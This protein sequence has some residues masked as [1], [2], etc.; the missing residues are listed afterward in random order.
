MSPVNNY[1][2]SGS[3]LPPDSFDPS[4]D[5]AVS[6]SS[7]GSSRRPL[8]AISPATA[9]RLESMGKQVATMLT[10]TP[11]NK[12]STRDNAAGDSLPCQAQAIVRSLGGVP[13]A[14]E[15]WLDQQ[16]KSCRIPSESVVAKW[17]HAKPKT[18]GRS[19]IKRGTNAEEDKSEVHYADGCW[20]SIPE[21]SE[22]L[23]EADLY[24]PFVALI[25]AALTKF[26]IR[27]REVVDNH[28]SYLGHQEEGHRTSPDLV[29]SAAGSSF[30]I[31][32]GAHAVGYSNMVTFFEVKLDEKLLTREGHKE[33][34]V[35]Y[36]R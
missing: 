4:R 19:H 18:T 33:Q 30:E 29:V 36:V 14:S 23:K 22:D 1:L 17:V 24:T 9:I 20:V 11:K 34:L 32:S 15:V 28:L 12:N 25:D 3:N 10:C 13:M 6:G 27:G 8:R 5:S 35:L 16:L 31:S 21:S 7:A 2:P 26:N